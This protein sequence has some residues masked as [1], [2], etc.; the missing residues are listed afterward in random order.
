MINGLI[1][2]FILIIIGGIGF[3]FTNKKMWPQNANNTFSIVV[4][5]IAAP[6]LAV[7]SIGNN[8]S[9]TMLIHSIK[10]LI[11]ILGC[12]MIM[13]M[14]G[15]IIA[16]FLKLSN[17]KKAVFITTF[18]FN[19]AMFIGLPVNQ[20][21]FGDEGL[22]YLFTYYLVTIIMFWSLG[23]YTLSSASSIVDNKFSIKNLISPGLSGV[24][25]GCIIAGLDIEIP[26]LIETTLT[27]L[28]QLTV[29]LAL[30]V[31]G[32]NLSFSVSRGL[33]KIRVDQIIILLGKFV[34]SPGLMFLACY[35]L[36]VDGMA[37]KVFILSASLPCHAQ[38]AIMA[39][40]YNV[41]GE[42]ASNLVSL[43][44]LVSIATIP[45]YATVLS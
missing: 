13:H 1:S 26:K 10:N 15:R 12:M 21:I 37:M 7:I 35:L 29:P 22:P 32:S 28:G 24:I 17:E 19:N 5:N 45:I 41:E 30:L 36:G 2:V 40:Y 25:I 33:S 20:I 18:T 42:Y 4:I 3:I 11:I 6:S 43:S 38:T 23:S 8:F 16:Y 31:I 27:Y 9:S 44:T 34:I 39:E 14:L